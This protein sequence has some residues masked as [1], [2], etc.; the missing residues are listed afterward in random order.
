MNP[1]ITISVDAK[2]RA[3]AKFDGL[4]TVGAKIDVEIRGLPQGIEDF[5]PDD[6]F[7]G[8]SV[9][10]RIVDHFGRDLVRYPLIRK[11]DGEDGDHWTKTT[12][13]SGD[14]YSTSEGTFVE[15][16][17]DVLRAEFRHMPFNASREFGVIID[18]CVDS[19]EF[20]LGEIEIFNWKKP[21]TDDPTILPD[22]RDLMKRIDTAK[23]TVTKTG[24]VATIEITDTRGV[25][26]VATVQDGHNGDGSYIFDE[27]DHKWHLQKVFTDPET[28]DKTTWVDPVGVEER[29][30]I[31]APEAYVTKVGNVVTITTKD[32]VHGTQTVSFEIP[33]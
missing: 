1:K 13:E 20:A 14:V 17:T 30:G 22:W 12:G 19:V 10:F 18:S 33:E 5:G 31:T 3:V 4:A 9:R 25:K 7:T 29:P 24:D 32:S 15:F 11:R 2:N 21:C 16:N 23:A 28:G 6:D 8:P 26:S 27:S